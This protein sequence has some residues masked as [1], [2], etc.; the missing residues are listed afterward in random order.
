MSSV[1]PGTN[2][3]PRRTSVPANKL[4]D[5]ANQET[6]YTDYSAEPFWL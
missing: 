6:V 2:R 3:K 1:C 5:L 4:C